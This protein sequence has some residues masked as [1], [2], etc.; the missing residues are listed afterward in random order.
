MPALG[1]K[2]EWKEGVVGWEPVGTS[3]VGRRCCP[4]RCRCGRSRRECRV[5]RQTLE[6]NCTIPVR[7]LGAP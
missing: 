7:M 4:A 5:R 3:Q 1:L 2:A 6:A